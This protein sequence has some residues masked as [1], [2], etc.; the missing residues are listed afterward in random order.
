[1]CVNASTRVK[2]FVAKGVDGI[3]ARGFYGGIHAEEK[4]DA[5]G[6]GYAEHYGPKGN[7]SGERGINGSR[8]RADGPSEGDAD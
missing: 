3:E 4:S 5:H 1:M 8:E 2:L 6:G 7:G